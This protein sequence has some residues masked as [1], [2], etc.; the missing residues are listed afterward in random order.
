LVAGLLIG[1]INAPQPDEFA[2]RAILKGNLAGLE[3]EPL[4][5]D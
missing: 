1:E 2:I 5:A 3:Y 4:L